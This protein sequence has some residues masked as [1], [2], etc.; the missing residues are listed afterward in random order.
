MAVSFFGASSAPN[1][2]GTE[3]NIDPTTYTLNF[4]KK[5]SSFSWTR[6]S[7]IGNNDTNPAWT[8][9][10]YSGPD[11]TG[12]ALSST[13]D[14]LSGEVPAQQFTVTGPGIASVQLVAHDF[15]FTAHAS[16]IVDDWVL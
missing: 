10:A 11:A 15:N 4:T 7:T 1:A 9:T 8:L 3:G 14:G 13:G 16:P 2:F 12:V 6:V 5:L